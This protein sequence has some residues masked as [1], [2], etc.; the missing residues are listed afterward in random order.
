M[1]FVSAVRI[2]NEGYQP[3]AISTLIVS[4]KSGAT[5]SKIKCFVIEDYMEEEAETG[6]L[7]KICLF[8]K[9]Q[10]VLATILYTISKTFY[11]HVNDPKIDL[12]SAE[13]LK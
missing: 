13:E 3:P 9:V 12:L 1:T 2:N 8:L 6:E 4:H 7:F 10:K 5:I 11:L